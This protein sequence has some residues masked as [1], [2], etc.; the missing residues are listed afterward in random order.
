[1][2]APRWYEYKSNLPG[3]SGGK[4]WFSNARSCSMVLSDD[5][6]N[7]IRELSDRRSTVIV[8]GFL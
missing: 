2:S 7:V 3:D 4:W 5:I 1:M 8:I 6:V